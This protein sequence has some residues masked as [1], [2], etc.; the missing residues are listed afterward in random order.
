MRGFAFNLQGEFAYFKSPE[1]TRSTYSFPFPTKTAIVGLL[2][3][4]MGEQRNEYISSKDYENLKIG[5]RVLTKPFT[6]GIKMNYW[7]TKSIVSISS[8]LKMVL[9]GDVGGPHGRGFTTQVKFDYLCKVAYQVYVMDSN[10]ESGGSNFYE[11]LKS[12]IKNR[13]YFYPPYLGHANLLA[14]LNYIGEFNAEAIGKGNFQT[15]VATSTLTDSSLELLNVGGFEMYPS[16]PTKYDAVQKLLDKK[17]NLYT[18]ISVP[19][20]YDTVI[21]PNLGNAIEVQVKEGFGYKIKLN[22]EE[23]DICV[24]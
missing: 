22:D 11:A 15:L 18:V 1:G 19:K 8:D 13:K 10:E 14:E 24:Y 9:P 20:N 2:A 17:S 16:V 21:V 3:A 23:L 5:V 12:R 6:Y 7:R 4:I